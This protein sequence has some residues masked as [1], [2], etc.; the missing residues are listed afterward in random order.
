[1]TDQNFQQAFRPG[2][3]ERPPEFIAAQQV[4]QLI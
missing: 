1:M 4:R 3:D 2:Y